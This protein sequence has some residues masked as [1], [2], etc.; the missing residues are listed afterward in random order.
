[1][2]DSSIPTC[3]FPTTVVFVDDSREFLL[4]VTLQLDEHLSYLAFD[5]PTHAL[6]Y[7]HKQR[8]ALDWLNEQQS[9]CQG[10][11]EHGLAAVYAELDNRKR[12]SEISV[13]IV[14]YAMPGMNGL[15]FCQ[16]IE[17]THVKKILLVGPGDEAL[18]INAL[19]KGLIHQYINKNEVNLA[20]RI[21]TCIHELQQHYFANMSELINRMLSLT[22][23]PILEDAQLITLFYELYHKHKIVEFYRLDQQGSMLMLDED[24]K[25]YMLH[26]KTYNTTN[27][28]WPLAQPIENCITLPSIS[29]YQCTYVY[30]CALEFFRGKTIVSYHSY[31]DALDA[32]QLFLA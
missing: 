26:I 32:E 3:Y 6:E 31:L 13:V 1:M 7:I 18:A 15:A 25:P 21:V 4:N 19:E 20:A 29:G 27:D 17:H 11:T 23:P 8:Y 14:D 30:N 16:Q 10:R 28:V 9:V 5:S 22:T 2:F 24:A 12:F